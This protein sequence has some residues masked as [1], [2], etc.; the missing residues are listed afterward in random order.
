MIPTP[1]IPHT[2][3]RGY[4]LLLSILVSGIILSI[5]VGIANITLKGLVLSSTSRES[6]FAFYAADG[7]N[8]CALY[9]D[10][11][12][13]GMSVSPFPTS[14]AS[15]APAGAVVCN[16]QDIS[17]GWSVNADATSATTIFNVT[18]SADTCAT[19]LVNKTNS[20]ADTRIESRGY[21]TC[22]LTEPRRLERAVRIRY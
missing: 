18:F 10:V 21:N 8:E 17:S 6:Q 13:E 15:A 3:E 20:G 22:D 11:K 9:W 7:G 2:R 12:F 1:Y 5:G 16:G 14:S 19:V 4:V